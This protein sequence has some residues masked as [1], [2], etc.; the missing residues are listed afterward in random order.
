MT[1][2]K[3]ARPIGISTNADMIDGSISRFQ[4]ELEAV[5]ASGAEYGE[6]ILHSL[7][8]I[9]NGTVDP[10]RLRE[11]KEICARFPLQY[12]M[13]L[14]FVLNILDPIRGDIHYRV[15][16]SALEVASELECSLVV[17][18]ASHTALDP[19]HVEKYYQ[20]TFGSEES[21][22]IRQRLLRMDAEKLSLLADRAATLGVAIALENPNGAE[23]PPSVA[24]GI[25]P[26]GLRNHVTMIGRKNLGITLD[27]GHLYIQS[28]ILGY[29]YREAIRILAPLTIHTH[30]HDNFGKSDRGEPY[31]QRL[32]YGLG[33]LHLPPGTGQV[34]I[35]ETLEILGQVDYRGIYMLEIEF[36]FWPYFADHVALFKR[37]FD[38]PTS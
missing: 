27:V 19:A 29:D 2:K 25:D 15:F 10:K 28:K 16:E 33:D 14:P 6:I 22:L 18:H 13:H 21:D 8:V 31:I 12:T 7:D 24:Y 30:V 34:P 37:R 1:P 35:D 4:E 20:G 11:V 26:T 17:Y 38:G 5:S 23:A 9:V 32:P 3:I 36:R